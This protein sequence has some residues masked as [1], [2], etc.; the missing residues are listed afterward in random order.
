MPL[1]G[2]LGRALGSMLGPLLKQLRPHNGIDIGAPIGNVI[3]PIA[4]EFF[5]AASHEAWLGN[6][7]VID[8]G[9]GIES[10]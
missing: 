8:H 2:R 6:R 7:L 10:V 5:T 3:M 4:L 9:H 1:E